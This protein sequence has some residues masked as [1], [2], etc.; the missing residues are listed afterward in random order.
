LAR[1]RLLGGVVLLLLATSPLAESTQG[2]AKRVALGPF[3][4]APIVQGGWANGDPSDTLVFPR[5]NLIGA[6]LYETLDADQGSLVMWIMPEWDGNDGKRHDFF[7][8]DFGDPG[9]VSLRKEG[10]LLILRVGDT[11]GTDEVGIN[12]SAWQAGQAHLVVGRW[13]NDNG[14]SGLNTICLSIDGGADSCSTQVSPPASFSPSNYIGSDRNGT[15][16]ANAIIEGLTVYRRPLFN[17]TNGIDVGNGNE[18]SLIWNGGSGR[19]PTSVTGSWDVVFCLPTDS[20]AGTLSTGTGEAWSHPHTSN[21]LYTDS[22][23]TG[24]FM[25][26]ASP[27]ADN[28]QPEPVG[29]PTLGVVPVNQK[30]YA[31]GFSV[32]SSGTSNEGIYRDIA[33]TAGDDWA[34]RVV[35]FRRH[36]PAADRPL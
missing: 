10:D 35:P 3:S 24:G 27:G 23:D 1:A 20:A 28:W 30:I 26:G 31:G 5:G 17:G 12:I 2:Q 32:R 13:D 7:N 25:L 16:P 21:L 4:A 11:A 29:T 8:N 15:N 34:V 19:D 18:V 36:L 9:R 14:L 6:A 33:V 22:S